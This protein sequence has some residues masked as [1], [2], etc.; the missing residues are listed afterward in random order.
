LIISGTGQQSNEFRNNSP[1]Q[2]VINNCIFE[3]GNSIS[4]DVW[5]NLGLAE[6][7]NVGYGAAIVADGQTVV[8]I[9]GS[10]IK[11]FEGPAV[12]ASNGARVSIDRNTVLD[13][14]GLRN[15]NTLSS[16]QTNVVCEGDSG[17]TTINI[18]L[19][20]VT[21][22]A[23]TGNAWIYQ[24]SYTNCF[25]TATV[26]YEPAQP[27]SVP[28][29]NSANITVD[30]K[31]QT[32]EV[33]INGKFLEPCMRTLF[34]GLIEKYS[35]DQR[36][37]QEFLIEN[38]L[39]TNQWISSEILVILIP[40]YLLNSLNSSFEWQ[41]SVYELGKKDQANWIT[42]KPSIIGEVGPDQPG[43]ETEVEP[44]ESKSKTTLI[45][46][47]VVPVVVIAAVII[48]IVVIALYVRHKNKEQ[49]SNDS[50]IQL[51]DILSGVEV[52][53]LKEEDEQEEQNN[54]N[55]QKH[56]PQTHV[57]TYFFPESDTE[58]RISSEHSNSRD[59]EPDQKQRQI[60]NQ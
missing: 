4:S 56:K 11:T 14:N 55:K 35:V 44:K 13:N 38:P 58:K 31:D 54:P 15:R 57:S 6:T 9:S 45:V 51:I 32:V 60:Q 39:F 10:T 30:N 48:I 29:G 23:S 22:F 52:R 26:N 47:I 25:V 28:Y 41:V 43:D 27:R 40:S 37:P 42:V 7:C 46:S 2:L 5:Y 49:R 12:R 19:D 24:Q 17:V 20:N 1:G 3:G 34:L 18:A 21:S 8:Q 59:Y 53:S 33:A 50:N 16:M 36:T